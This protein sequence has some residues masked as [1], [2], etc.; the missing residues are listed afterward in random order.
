M[1]QIDSLDSN[2]FTKPHSVTS[3]IQRFNGSTRF[4]AVQRGSTRFNGKLCISHGKSHERKKYLPPRR[5]HN[6]END[7]PI[8]GST[9]ITIMSAIDPLETRPT[10]SRPYKIVSLITCLVF[11]SLAVRCSVMD[12]ETVTHLAETESSKLGVLKDSAPPHFPQNPFV[13]AIP[14][15][16]WDKFDN[17]EC[18]EQGLPSYPPEDAWER[19]APYAILM[20]A[21]K[22]GTT[23]LAEYLYQHPMIVEPTKYKE[24]H[25]FDFTY[26]TELASSDGI[27]R[28]E[29]RIRYATLMERRLGR[30]VMAALRNS[31]TLVAIDDSPRYQLWSDR[32]P[33]R[34]LCIAPWAKILAILRNPIDR[35]YSHYNQL[36]QNPRTIKSPFPP[37]SFEEWVAMDIKLLKKTGVV[38]NKIDQST[39]AGSQEEMEAWKAYIRSGTHGPIGRGLYALQLRHWF[40]AYESH[41]KNRSDFLIINSD[42]MRADKYVVNREVLQ[43]LGL[44]H[45]NLKTEKEFNAQDYL[46]M[47]NRTRSVLQDFYEPYNRQLYDLLGSAWEGAWDP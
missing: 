5:L 22:S 1:I 18:I 16:E 36:L 15:S 23:A 46:P 4:N 45:K 37:P 40:R 9:A 17:Q 11:I 44:P 2:I 21:M 34:V 29:S 6:S 3:R 26:D 43:F 20:G 13:K 25:F 19:R 14:R 12:N 41:G 39:F 42:R 28:L 31:S 7:D 27:H 38:Q 33:A 32:I 8:I 24:I 30:E 10:L 47:R 35:A